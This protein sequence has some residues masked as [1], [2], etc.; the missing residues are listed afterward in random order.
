MIK[1]GKLKDSLKVNL[2]KI[3]SQCMANIKIMEKP[4]NG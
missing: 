1:A 3:G 2:K 4:I